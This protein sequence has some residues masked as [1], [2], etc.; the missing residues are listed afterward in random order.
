MII[1]LKMRPKTSLRKLDTLLKR[2]S[3]TS[4]EAN[5]YGVSTATLIHYVKQGY[6]ERIA[7]G[8]YR[9]PTSPRVEDLRWEDLSEAI[10]KVPG[11]V[12]CLTSA[13]I[14]Y[15]LTEEMPRQHWIAVSYL[16][17]PKTEKETK[18]VR[19]RNM[20]L[21]RTLLDLDGVKLPIFDRERSIIDAFRH[22]SIETAI[23][24]LKRGLSQRPGPR[25]DLN[26]LQQYAKTLRVDITP[27]LI[28]LTI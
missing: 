9:A 8:I 15:E 18:I 23:K 1:K 3:F 14:L 17:T 5:G 10:L 27:Y 25:I 12:I 6:L 13:L 26:K 11:G 7:R 2:P 21:G 4:K 16:K 28:S 22:L 20:E 19:M 24:A